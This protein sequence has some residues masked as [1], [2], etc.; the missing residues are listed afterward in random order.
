MNDPDPTVPT[1]GPAPGRQDPAANP[2]NAAAPAA[3]SDSHGELRPLDER[4]RELGQLLVLRLLST[5][6]VGRAYQV[7]NQ[8]FRAQLDL[9]LGAIGPMLNEF[10]ETVLVALETDLYLNGVRIPMTRASLRHHQAA[11]KEFRRRKIAGLKIEKGVTR[12]ELEKFFALFLQP[13]VYNS[14]GLLE[15]ALAGGCDHVQPA[16]YASTEAPGDDE[17]V[18]T[19]GEIQES[20]P[21]NSSS[22]Y[23]SSSTFSGGGT[24]DPGADP[25]GSD[26]TGNAPRGAA[27]KSFTQAIAGTRS[28]LTTTALQNG[29]EMRHA[30]RVVQPLV[31]GAF[32]AEPVV[33]GL[34]T[35]GHH[36]EY[37]YMHAVN[38]CM[39]AVTMGHALGLDRRALA[40]LGAAA[41]LHDVGKNAVH[42]RI[43][44]PI[45]EW[46][47]AER[48]AAESHVIEGAKLLARS[49]TLNATTL[50]CIRVALE[51]HVA[52]GYPDLGGAK[53][54]VLSRLVACA[55]CYTSLQTHRSER[56][57]SV[58][59][60]EAL[61][62]MLGPLAS[63]FEPALLWALV[64]SVGF[65]PPGQ[66]VKLD[67]GA[68][69]LVL[70]PNP[71][72]LARPHVRVALDSTGQAL[73]AQAPVEFRPLP[74]ERSI[75]AALAAAEYPETDES[76]RAA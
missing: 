55:D 21:W 37:T 35:L 8:T 71:A 40:D 23:R 2:T 39:V 9:L 28:L 50:R 60:F 36:D 48:A 7:G 59:P 13:E 57:R 67:D 69:A 56:G 43:T 47:E 19:P 61:G 10:G 29:M 41:L 31:D 22:G 18:F 49:T 64:Q 73:P 66:I 26:R 63:S 34:A 30:K 52:A 20:G 76:R 44:H 12:D 32:A 38:V 27:P 65:Y 51:H 24:S 25:G 6:R 3:P 70:A 72:D 74:A 5:T 53:P 14:T 58:T 17:M 62:M 68:I 1:P 11:L 33:M 45:G 54:S 16:I 15:A 75:T 4:M 42:D 46:S